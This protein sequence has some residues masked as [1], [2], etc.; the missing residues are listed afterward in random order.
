MTKSDPMAQRTDSQH[1]VIREDG[2]RLF[3]V[4]IRYAHVPELELMA[5]LAGMRLRERWADWDRS[6][7]SSG[8]GKHISVWEHD[9]DA[10]A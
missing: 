4:K 7:F 1:V 5:R 9:P 6:P 2:I 3:P 8:S 10:G